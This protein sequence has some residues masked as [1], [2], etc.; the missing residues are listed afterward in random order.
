MKLQKLTI[1]NWACNDDEINIVH[2]IKLQEFIRASYYDEILIKPET[3]DF[4]IYKKV[5]VRTLPLFEY[6]LHNKYIKE[7]MG[8]YIVTK[9]IFNED[10]FVTITTDE[11]YG[12]INSNY[13]NTDK[14]LLHFIRLVKSLDY[15][16][17]INSRRNVIG[18]MS[19]QFFQNTYGLSK[20]T[21][22]SYNK[23]LEDLELLYIVRQN[24][25]INNIYG[26]YVD[27]KYINK[28]ADLEYDNSAKSN[29]H[30]SV[31]ARYNKYM[32]H[33]ESFS[34]P[35]IKRLYNDCLKYNQDMPEFAKAL[36]GINF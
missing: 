25:K 28:Y 5:G 3:L 36:D 35:E 31:S 4:F 6:L 14:L 29:F 17:N 9:D 19:V 10:S 7:T 1:P 2:Y 33:P 12:I 15:N 20:N 26:R 27:K 21:I 24:G 22:I 11:F 13:K 34:K 23:K 18:H 30:R 32:K 16:I 8:F